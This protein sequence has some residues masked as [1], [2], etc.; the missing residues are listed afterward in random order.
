M[1]SGQY[2]FVVVAN[3]L[4][5]DR[6]GT[7]EDGSPQYETSPGG[8][9]TALAP[10]MTAHR[11]AWVGWPGAPGEAGEPFDSEGMHLVPV[12]LS[13]EDVEDYYEGMSN[14]TLWPLFHD[15]IVAPEYHRSW[16]D[17]YERV[18]QRFADAA[19]AQA[20]QGAT[21]WVQDYQLLLVPAR[22]R[23][24]RPDLKIGFFNHIPFPGYEIFS[25]LPW[26]SQV[27]EG[28]LGADLV[29][30]QRRGDAANFLRACRRLGD[31]S[32]KGGTISVAGGRTVRAGAFPISIDSRGFEELASA[33]EVMAR[34]EQIRK[35]L[36]DPD[37]VLLG[38]DRLDYTKG[39][40]HRLTCFSELLAD[41]RLGTESA[42][43]VQV[44]SPSRER[45]RAYSDLRDEVELTVGRINGDHGTVGFQPV[46][47]L[48]QSFPREE[49]A[50]LYLAADVML[51][52]ALRDGM[53]LVAKEYV[54]A[55]HDSD[56]VLVLSEFAGAADE[57]TQAVLINPHDIAGTKA[58]VLRA[59]QMPRD[60]RRRRM[61]AL[62][63]RVVE[64][65]VERWAA[66]FLDAL[67]GHADQPDAG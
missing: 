3:R 24:L 13:H 66:G 27:V 37:T 28:V 31:A 43:L 67:A 64:H 20:A 61:R 9:V 46:H 25:Q 38:V 40:R 22:L 54:A 32:T 56:G 50:A 1:P 44:A 4:P 39:I 16:W 62:R 36:G 33:P 60:E 57:L 59:V 29:G 63:R 34:A 45:V 49:M 15:V 65:D 12:E 18:N 55:R 21:V 47:Y 41:G 51:V 35:E 11:G 8:L 30:F 6:V 19:A 48:H 42:V 7:A 58:A 53:N 52:T 14:G 10:V 5:V 17:A 26:R 23:A 2:D